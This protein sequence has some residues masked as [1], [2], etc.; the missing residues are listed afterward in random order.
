MRKPRF[1]RGRKLGPRFRNAQGQKPRK[2]AE[3]SRFQLRFIYCNRTGSVAGRTSKRTRTLPGKSL[4]GGR[5]TVLVAA[6][7]LFTESSHCALPEP[8]FQSTP[9]IRPEGSTDT[10]TSA[11]NVSSARSAGLSQLERRAY[12]IRLL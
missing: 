7:A 1:F 8:F 10:S 4:G 5:L 11:T 6:M 12:S 2:M 9:V 3:N